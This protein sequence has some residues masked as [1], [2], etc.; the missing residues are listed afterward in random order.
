MKVL[1]YLLLL[2]VLSGLYITYPIW[3]PASGGT[4]FEYEIDENTQVEPDVVR[5]HTPVLKVNQAV[6][7]EAKIGSK[8]FVAY[9][10]RVPEQVQTYWDKTLK[11]DESIY[12]DICTPLKATA[13]GWSTSC[14]YKIKS[15][16][17]LS[18]LIL[19]NY[20]I[21]NGELVK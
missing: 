19:S 16:K 20:S 6:D 2:I 3:A 10:S 11:A 13:K 5:K 15:D 4:T 8:P 9:Q 7:L 21:K 12:E 18:S 1:K 17:G 14:Q